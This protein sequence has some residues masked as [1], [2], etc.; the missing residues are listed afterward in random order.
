MGVALAVLAVVQLA[1]CGKITK[2]TLLK[3]VSEQMADAESYADEYEDG[4]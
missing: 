2:L 4:P 1:G 3:K